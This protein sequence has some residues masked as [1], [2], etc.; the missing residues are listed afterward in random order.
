[1]DTAMTKSPDDRPCRQ[2]QGSSASEVFGGLRHYGG[3]IFEWNRL[4]SP[5][6]GTRRRRQA[7][8]SLVGCKRSSRA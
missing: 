8:F 2:S 3:K 5:A 6:P 1:M 4:H 7:P